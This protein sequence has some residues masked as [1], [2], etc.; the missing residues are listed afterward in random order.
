M[1]SGRS[2]IFTEHSRSCFFSATTNSDCVA[3][4]GWLAGLWF[5]SCHF[6]TDFLICK[7]RWGSQK[8]QSIKFN[9]DTNYGLIVSRLAACQPVADTLA[10]HFNNRI[11]KRSVEISRFA[12]NHQPC[13][14]SY[15]WPLHLELELAYRWWG[16]HIGKYLGTPFAGGPAIGRYGESHRALIIICIRCASI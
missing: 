13:G 3:R 6:S 9:Y 2:V 12:E 8:R 1:C 16:V 5:F 15:K 11:I 7:L 4:T 14:Q 10:A